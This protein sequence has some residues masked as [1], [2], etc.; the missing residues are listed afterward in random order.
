MNIELE[1]VHK[2]VPTDIATDEMNWDAYAEH[3]DQMCKFNTSY[4]EN[5]QI[6]LDLVASW[7]LPEGANVCDLGAGTGN[8]ITALAKTRPDA[9][10]VHVDFDQKMN[11]AALRKYRQV[12]IQHVQLVTEYV[13][14]CD[15]P[16]ESFDLIMCVNALYAISPQ[17]EV[18]KKVK[19]WLKP[20]GRFFVIDFGR[21]QK[22]LD[23][24]IYLFRE[25]MKNRRAGEYVKALINSREVL[26]QNRRSTK[27]QETGRYWLHTTSEFGEAL[28]SCGFEIDSLYSCYRGY[29]DLAICKN[30]E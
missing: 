7:P 16:D 21:K 25:S 11:E 20:N 23:W 14:D 9:K 22:T 29:A 19:R 28:S 4:Q 12:D 30:S 8:Y 6:L 18:L 10:F 17:D 27:G 5:V 3:Y 24:T 13:Q 2:Y 15:F 26:K 1:D